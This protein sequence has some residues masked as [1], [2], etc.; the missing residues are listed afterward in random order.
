MFPAKAPKVPPN[1][2]S[3]PKLQEPGNLS[4]TATAQEGLSEFSKIKEPYYVDPKFAKAL[5]MRTPRN[6]LPN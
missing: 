6:G 2:R 5:A 4:S 1:G 3:F